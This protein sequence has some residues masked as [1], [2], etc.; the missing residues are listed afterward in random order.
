MPV[1]LKLMIS[2]V[3][4]TVL[5]DLWTS[6]WLGVLAVFVV[7]VVLIGISHAKNLTKRLK[8]LLEP[9]WEHRTKVFV[10]L[11][12]VFVALPPLAKFIYEEYKK[13]PQKCNG[14]EELCNRRFDE[15][16]P[17]RSGR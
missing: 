14:H 2:D 17:I 16:V 5:K 4:V 1:S 8:K 13:E 9:V 6:V 3:V 10:G 15:V 12:V 7:G 11:T